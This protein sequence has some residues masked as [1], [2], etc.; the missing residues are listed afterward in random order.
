M[1][2]TIDMKSDQRLNKISMTSGKE[3]SMVKDV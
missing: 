3:L 1:K 2:K